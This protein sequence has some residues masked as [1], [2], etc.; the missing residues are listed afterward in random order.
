MT[1]TT[2]PAVDV[3]NLTKSYANGV[4]AVQGISF[5]VGAGEI[6]GVLGPNGAGKSTTLNILTTLL[7]AT[8][9]V[10]RI[11]GT[12]V[13]E[14]E[15]VARL[16]GV[17]LQETG[18]DPLMTVRRHFDV[19]GVHYRMPARA[20]RERTDVLL[21]R[22]SLTEFANRRAGQMSGGQ[23]RR[24]GLAL[25]LLHDPQLLI[26][27]EP[28]VGLDPGARSDLWEL[29]VAERARGLTVLFS[30]HDM[31]EAEELC[32]RLVVFSA[33]RVVDEG[34]PNE[35]RDRLGGRR[36]RIK[37]SA[38]PASSE[39]SGIDGQPNGV[40]ADDGTW[41]Q[42]DVD[43]FDRLHE[44]FERLV[45]RTDLQ[46]DEVHWERLALEDLFA[47]LSSIAGRPGGSGRP[48]LE[49]TAMARRG[50]SR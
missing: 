42:L 36:A 9:G 31:R 28:T 27:D 6:V 10:A 43:C 11:F 34:T 23:Q 47:D 46:V 30:T 22:F 7:Q 19:Q 18:L 33:G 2:T 39:T 24:V 4:D 44:E 8:S 14:R 17:A 50:A 49:P 48:K 16:V 1:S 12:D 5:R 3:Q 32:D 20:V 13:T 15:R 45:G 38:V 40:I 29:I 37:T 41:M 26:F 21:E 35:V 25:A